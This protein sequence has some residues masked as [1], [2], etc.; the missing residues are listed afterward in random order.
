VRVH[1]TAFIAPGAVVQGRVTLGRN[2]SVWYHA[3]LRGDVEPIV[4]GEDTN[5]QDLSVMHSDEGYPCTVGQRCVVGHGAILHGCLV[6]NECLIGMGAILLTGVRVGEGS[7]VG[8]GAVVTE[9]T[10]VPPG[11]LVLG[12]PAKVVR[13]VS[14]AERQLT[15]EGASHYVQNAAR[16]RGGEFS[17][18]PSAGP[19]PTPRVKRRA[20]KRR[21]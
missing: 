21:V 8:A 17:V 16:H 12:I 9:G 10:V 20:K 2:A 11:S 15:R 18:Q 14:E 13:S 4:V 1:P 6:E 5:I 3:V 19:I 7:V